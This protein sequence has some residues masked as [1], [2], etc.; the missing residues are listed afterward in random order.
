M[1]GDHTRGWVH[2][3]KL[4]QLCEKLPLRNDSAL[5]AADVCHA[6]QLLTGLH[7]IDVDLIGPDP[8]QLGCLLCERTAADHERSWEQHCCAVL[9]LQ[10]LTCPHHA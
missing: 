3:Y 4:E 2:D 6:C 1:A 10:Q 9:G 5:P 7:P 8:S